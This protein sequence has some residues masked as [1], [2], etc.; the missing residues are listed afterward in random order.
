MYTIYMSCR[1]L[2]MYSVYMSCRHLHMYTIYMALS[3]K[4][5]H[6]PI[7]LPQSRFT[8]R[9]ILLYHSNTFSAT[10]SVAVVLYDG[11][12]SAVEIVEKTET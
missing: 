3:C 12:I 6:V 1:D 8:E 5:L 7:K 4:H 11:G 9:T 2:Y 10:D